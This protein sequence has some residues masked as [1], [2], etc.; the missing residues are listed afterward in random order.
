MDK[1]ETIYVFSD[2]PLDKTYRGKIVR[3][4]VLCPPIRESEI[5]VDYLLDQAREKMPRLIDV[6]CTTWIE[7]PF[8]Q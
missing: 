7:G 1:R 8:T 4:F 2:V 3:R 6:V 5:A